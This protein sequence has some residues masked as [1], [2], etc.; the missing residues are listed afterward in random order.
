MEDKEILTIVNGLKNGNHKSIS[1]SK[2]SET[3]LLKIAD[4]L[5]E[6]NFDISILINIILHNNINENCDW[7]IG[8]ILQH[9][10]YNEIIGALQNVSQNRRGYLYDSIGFCWALGECPYKNEQVI[11]F[12]YEVINNGRNSESWWRAAFALEKITGKNAINNLKR[13][14]KN[15]GAISLEDS[16]ED[17]SDKKNVINVLLHANSN[18][19]REVIYPRLKERFNSSN[20][21]KELVNII[22]LSGRL[23]L[24]DESMLS[25]SLEIL[26]TTSSYETKYYILQAM[27]DDPKTIYLKYFREFLDSDDKLIKKM[28]IAGLAELGAKVD[29]TE[30]ERLLQNEKSPNVI[31]SLSK[32]IYMVKNN[33]FA[34]ERNYI[35]KYMVN[36][37]G[38]IG[39]DSD[40]WYADASIYNLFSEAEDPENVCFNIIFNRLLSEKIRVMNPVDLATGTGRAAKFILNNISYDGTLYAVDYSKQMLEYFERTINRQKYYVKDIHLQHSKIEDF[41]I[42]NGEKSSFIISSFGFPSKISDKDRCRNELENVFDLLTDDGVFVTLGWDETFNDDLNN[43]WYKYIPDNI[44]AANFEEWRKMREASIESARNCMLTWYKK[45]IKVPL[46]YDTLEETINVMGHLFGRDAALEILKNKR[47]MWWMSLGITWDNKESL[48]RILKK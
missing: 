48:A 20:S 13:S 44:R 27:I 26:E 24:Y 40:K 9:F 38:L 22:W 30:L 34:E 35:R 6:D 37:N 46:L 3:N 19:I 2:I 4:K 14:L 12:L 33:Y 21:E 5:K 18:V 28:A 41:K 31:S 11:E 42:P 25:K 45:N 39:D 32:A 10:D 47:T 1:K 36:E 15:Y 43:M 7:N 23:R 8:S 16:L 29:V 17:L